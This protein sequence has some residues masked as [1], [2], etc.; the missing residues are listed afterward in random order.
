MAQVTKCDAAAQAGSTSSLAESVY[1]AE[2]SLVCTSLTPDELKRLL[3]FFG[4]LDRWEA[5]SSHGA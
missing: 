5:G 1:E 3:D 2:R 4:L